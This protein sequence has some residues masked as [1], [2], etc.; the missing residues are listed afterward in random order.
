M[1]YAQATDGQQIKPTPNQSGYCPCC[2]S[3]VISKCGKTNIWHWAHESK[4]CDPWYEPESEWH[5]SWKL[6]V[7]AEQTEVV[8]HKNNKKHRADIRLRN[9]LVVELQ[10]S[11]ISAEEIEAREAFYRDMIWLFDARE[12]AL[13][14]G[15]DTCVEPICKYEK[16][17]PYLTQAS[18]WFLKLGHLYCFPE[19]EEEYF[20]FNLA[21]AIK[22]L[23]KHGAG[24]KAVVGAITEAIP[25]IDF[26]L[27]SEMYDE[28]VHYNNISRYTRI[29]G[30]FYVLPTQMNRHTFRWRWAHRT[31]AAA[32]KPLYFQISD[33]Q[34]LRITKLHCFATYAFYPG[35]SAEL[36]TREEF[37]SRVL[38]PRKELSHAS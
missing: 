31:L 13:E 15:T 33:N 18:D 14:V 28:I 30:P 23:S 17:E 1:L 32:K 8:I 35:G 26:G 7:P 20:S 5:R 4:D 24:F 9:G 19:E 29:H 27:V 22:D 38:N 10:H 11:S 37:I 6:T 12:W 36:L 3:T 2:K 34:I 16:D 25:Q 21:L